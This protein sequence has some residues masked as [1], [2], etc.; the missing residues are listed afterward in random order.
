MDMHVPAF[1]F[2]RENP[3]VKILAVFMARPWEIRTLA[4]AGIDPRRARKVIPGLAEAFVRER[5][6]CPDCQA[7]LARDRVPCRRHGVKAQD[8]QDR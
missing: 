2:D 3:E 4:A 5:A 1:G 7:F 6:A 8:D